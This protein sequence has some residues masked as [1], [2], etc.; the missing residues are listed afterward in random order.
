MILLTGA[1][2]DPYPALGHFIVLLLGR[3]A[4]FKPNATADTFAVVNFLRCNTS[5]IEPEAESLALAALFRAGSTHDP[6]VAMRLGV[7]TSGELNTAI[8]E[9]RFV[10]VRVLQV[11]RETVV[12]RTHA[13][14]L[15]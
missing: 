5:C 9:C 3:Y 15:L 11:R 1:L 2:I 14:R 10:Q 13:Y 4:R 7:N 12:H 6:I 8:D